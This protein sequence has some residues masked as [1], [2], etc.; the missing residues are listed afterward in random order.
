MVQ[1]SLIKG[2][3]KLNPD[4]KRKV[5]ASLFEDPSGVDK[6]LSSF[7]HPDAAVQQVLSELS[8]NTLSNYPLPYNVAPNFIINGRPFLVPMVIEESS[9]VAAASSAARFWAD[10][11]G[12]TARVIDTQKVG[13]VHFLFKG[14]HHR[15][16]TAFPE[17]ETF[18]MERVEPIARNMV[19]RGGG[20]LG[21]ELRNKTREIDNF[22][23]LHLTF[24]TVDAMGANFINSVLEECARGLSDYFVQTPGFSPSEYEPLMSIL[25]NHTPECLVEV[26]V[27]CP[28]AG[29]SNIAPG[30]TA[31]DF[32]RRF[33]LAVRIAEQ[34]IHRAA[35]HNKGIMNGVDA[36][37]LATGNDFRAI[38]AAAHAYAAKDGRYASLSHAKVENGQ[39]EF[40]LTMPMALGTTGGLT[41]L[42]P[43]AALSLEMLGKPNARELM[44]IAA[45]AGL[46]N[47]FAAVRSL[48]TTG[49]QAGHMRMH[50]PNILTQLGA[51]PAE[52]NKTAI[53][54]KD[55]TISFQKVEAYLKSLRNQDG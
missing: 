12:F 45:A 9:V 34:D 5:V 19:K 17:M 48:T 2:F 28:V 25:S 10:R 16:E 15:F 54:F 26:K 46:A 36:V 30:T 33:V 32:A 52:R 31:E 11:G 47:N 8:E 20:I 38:E 37:I 4:E 50:L 22:F 55:Q 14:D 51:T 39:F 27:A 21:M 29:L 44:M 49:I 6:T 35:T 13:Q 23:Q 42:H 3:S 1:K 18:L 24:E 40:S 7:F 43:L 41:R 53:F